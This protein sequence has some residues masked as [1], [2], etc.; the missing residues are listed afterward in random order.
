MKRRAAIAAALA[1][2]IGLHAFLILA[3]R[4]PKPPLDAAAARVPDRM[5]YVSIRFP[6][7]PAADPLQDF[8]DS[9]PQAG[10]EAPR[11]LR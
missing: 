5:Y 2:S 1:F 3:G 6:G 9:L 8:F 4:T 7:E 11:I 10:T